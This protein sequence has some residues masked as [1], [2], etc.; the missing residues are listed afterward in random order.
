MS[1]SVDYFFNHDDDLAAIAGKINSWIGC[2]LVPYE[3]DRKELFSR[4]LGMELSLSTHIFEND[5]NLNFEDYRYHLGKNSHSR[6]RP[7]RDANSSDGA[8]RLCV[9]LSS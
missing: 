6:R 7:S 4:F 5:R 9:V 1:I 2:S 8:D 3:G